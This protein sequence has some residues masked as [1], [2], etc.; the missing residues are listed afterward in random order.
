MEPPP[1][2][3]LQGPQFHTSPTLSKVGLW[4]K[5]LALAIWVVGGFRESS[6]KPGTS[7]GHSI[8]WGERLLPLPWGRP[9]PMPWELGQSSAWVL[10]TIPRQVLPPHLAG[11]RWVEVQQRL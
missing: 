8:S 7:E 11:V 4:G 2:P 10:H 6:P 9:L 1:D 3:S 5:E